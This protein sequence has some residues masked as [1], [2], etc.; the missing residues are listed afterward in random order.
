MINVCAEHLQKFLGEGPPERLP[1][2]VS[3]YKYCLRVILD[4]NPI[5]PHTSKLHDYME[6]TSLTPNYLCLQCPV[7]S[8]E[9]N[10]E[11]HGNDKSHRFCMDAWKLAM[12]SL[13]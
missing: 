2:T 11:S 10:L 7:I 9:Q 3:A 8:T 5:I 4:N 1:K 13:Y 12:S 6:V